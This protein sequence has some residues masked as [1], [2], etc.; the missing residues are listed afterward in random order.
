MG[1]VPVKTGATSWGDYDMDGDLDLLIT[2]NDIDGP[3]A[4]IYRN[5]EGAMVDIEAGLEGLEE[6]ISDW[7]D[8][9]ND[10][11]LDLVITGDWVAKIYRND[12]G[13]FADLEI[14]FGYFNSS[15]AAWG[16]YDNDGDLDLL[17]TGDS[18]AGAVS[19]VYRNDAGDFVEL[20][21]GLPGVMAGKSGWVDFDN[22]ADLDI[23][24]TGFNDALEAQF[25]LFRN[26]GHGIF[27]QITAW[28]PGVAK[29]SVAWGDIDNDGDQDVAFCGKG[30]GCGLF[31]SGIYR[32]DGDYF[33]DINADV[34]PLTDGRMEWADYDN[35]G[36]LDLF[37]TG[38][39]LDETPQTLIYRNEAG[40]N[41]FHPNTLPVNPTQYSTEVSGNNVTFSWNAG[42]D[43]ETPIEGLSYNLRLST[44]SNSCNVWSPMAEE[45]SGFRR[46][47]DKGNAGQNLSWTIEGLPE[48][49][50]YWSVQTI[51]QAFAGS[52]FAA[53][54]TFNV[55]ATSI[56]EFESF[57]DAV[58]Y[59]AA[60][61]TL[62]VN[63]E[64]YPEFML[65]IFDMQ[66]RK[67]LENK[68]GAS[69]YLQD[70]EAGIYIV[71]FASE[72]RVLAAKISMA[73]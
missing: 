47:A 32:N 20:G 35:D 67:L 73:K 41:T 49:E 55:T 43:S 52:A 34:F 60:A 59:N 70:F 23:Y 33:T 6:G 14:D 50:Y 21:A 56:E 37:S 18:G 17:L 63:A 31:V 12:D 7:G 26:N 39:H 13:V 2:G 61:K 58:H 72:G 62:E 11:D 25:F 15:S 27:E 51:D 16:D 36:D 45:L 69:V 4:R 40:D 1:L 64:E 54:K 9:D 57:E 5:D 22:D 66:G 38:A 65:M 42:S 10:G 44:S 30:S 71:R 24:L 29:S 48:G 19:I 8:Y 68:N 46:I 28:M 3:S 53:E